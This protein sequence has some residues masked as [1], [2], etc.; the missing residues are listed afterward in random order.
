MANLIPARYA[1]STIKLVRIHRT[2]VVDILNAQ[3]LPVALLDD[4]PLEGTLDAEQYG[5]LFMSLLKAS[6]HEL[7]GDSDEA[8]DVLNLSAYRLLYSYML[9]AQDLGGAIERA[10]A[11]YARFQRQRQGFTMV[12]DGDFAVW[13]FNL[14]GMDGKQKFNGSKEHFALDELQW[15]PGF[16]GRIAALYTW[17]RL[18]SWMI[19]NFIDLTSLHI[20]Y[21]LLGNSDD[22]TASFRA[23]V[24]FNQDY[25]QLRFHRRYLALPIIKNETDLEKMLAT[26]PAELLR[27]DAVADSTA[28]QVHGLLGTDFSRE[29]PSLEQV[30]SRLHT[31]AAT[32]HRRLRNEG[33]SYQMIKDNCRRDAAISLLR[34]QSLT[35]SAIAEKLGFSDASTFFR[36]FKKWTG[37]TPQEFVKK[38]S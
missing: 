13:Q 38:E 10:T 7:Q 35:G 31:T 29:L 25:C 20:D 24:Y 37:T 15:L 17:H 5:K 3:Q 11:Y 8:D 23:P 9:H 18:S 2:A 16:S 22:Y 19:G 34:T 21:A 27:A 4:K 30:A 33:T 32:L 14:G 28:A 26:F 36:A 6:Q 1:Q 12:I